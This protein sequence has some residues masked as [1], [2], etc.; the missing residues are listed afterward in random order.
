MIRARSSQD[1]RAQSSGH[2]NN[3]SVDLSR[4]FPVEHFSRTTVH[5]GIYELNLLEADSIEVGALGKV[6]T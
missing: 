4:R 6:L 5:L 1:R 2:C 3:F